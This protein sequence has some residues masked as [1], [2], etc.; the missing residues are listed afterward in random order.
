MGESIRGTKEAD[1]RN[2]LALLEEALFILDELGMPADIG[3]QVDLAICRLREHL[4]TS[5]PRP[6]GSDV[7]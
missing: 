5:A 1:A 7:V 6:G 3:A 4:G 2:A